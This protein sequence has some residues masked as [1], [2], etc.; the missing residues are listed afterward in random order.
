MPGA[1]TTCTAM[2]SS[3]C[4]IGITAGWGGSGFVG[5]EWREE[6]RWQLFSREAWRGLERSAAVLPLGDAAALRAGAGQRSYRVS[7]GC[8]ASGLRLLETGWRLHD[9]E[10]LAGEG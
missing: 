4:G 10:P 8:R 7:S 1:F 2:S 5:R 3:A 9:C 6:S